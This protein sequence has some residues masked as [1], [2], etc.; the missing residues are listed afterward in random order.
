M[1]KVIATFMEKKERKQVRGKKE[2]EKVF[3]A[4]SMEGKW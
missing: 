4:A 3:L 1:V 2:K